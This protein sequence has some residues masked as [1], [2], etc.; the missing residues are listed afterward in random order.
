MR[1]I[2]IEDLGARI[3]DL[4]ATTPKEQVLLTLRGRPFAFVTNASKYDW[5]DIGYMTD[6]E[7]WKM[8]EKRQQERPGIP[9]EV[10]EAKLERLERE[11]AYRDGARKVKNARK[12]AS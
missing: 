2:A 1:R 3:K 12:K 11:Q 9:L 10:V 7:F 5:E 8:I 4:I 6:P